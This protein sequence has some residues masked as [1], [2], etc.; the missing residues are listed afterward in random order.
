MGR[1]FRFAGFELDEQRAELRGPDGVAIR[2]R[3]K[4]FEMLRL[5]ASNAGRILSKQELIEAVWPNVHVSEDGLFQCVREIRAAL[6]DDQRQMIRLVSG[7]GYLFATKVSIEVTAAAGSVQAASPVWESTPEMPAISEA[8]REEALAKE[9]LVAPERV[10]QS[11]IEPPVVAQPLSGTAPAGMAELG[12]SRFRLRRPAAIAVVVGLCA[13]AGGVV[14]TPILWS[15][16]LFKRPPPVVA[17]MPIVDTSDDPQGGAMAAG[18]TDRL[19]EGFAKIDG[20][21][22]AV[23]RSGTEAPNAAAAPAVP[24]DFVLQGELQLGPQAWT[25]RTRL[26]RTATGEMEAVAMVSV[27]RQAGDLHLQ[28]TRLAAGVGY[29]LAY[30]LNGVLEH[31]TQP[32]GDVK[33]AIDQATAAIN[34]TTPERFA[35]AQAMLEKSIE[36]K[37][38]NVELQVALAGLQLRGIMMNWYAPAESADAQGKAHALLKL[39]LRAKPRFIPVLDAQ[40][41]FLTATNQFTESLVACARALTFDPWNGAALYNIG[42]AQL[43]LGRFDDALAT[44]EQAERFDTPVVSRWTWLLGAGWTCLVLGNNDAAL[45]FLQRSIAITPAS[46]RSYFL[47][48]VA[49]QRLGQSEKAKEAFRKAMDFRPDWT[50][51]NV[52]PSSVNTSPIYI[53][54]TKLIMNELSEMGLPER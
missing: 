42:L 1:V 3:P 43:K 36:D 51:L 44:F 52:Q 33:V 20:I 46:G 7:R 45:S 19:I 18:I 41:R 53:D 49:Y 15:S 11:V 27:D 6:R 35:T 9:A 2:L 54:K 23:P 38:E 40:C 13:M 37:P 39:A 32:D 30:D 5:F 47:L 29:P 8:P 16:S 34:R 25:L 50:A 48:A 22:V 31:G 14:A 10:A 17:M 28:Q 12:R 21:R 24:S 26:M 4:T